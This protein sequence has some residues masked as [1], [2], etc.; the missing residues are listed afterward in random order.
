MMHQIVFTRYLPRINT[1]L[2]STPL[3]KQSIQSAVL[4]ILKQY[5]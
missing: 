2:C 1:R 3:V 4:S 5:L